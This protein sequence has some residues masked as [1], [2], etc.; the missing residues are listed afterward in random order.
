[1]ALAKEACSAMLENLSCIMAVADAREGVL[2]QLARIIN[3][4]TAH[5]S[6]H[7]SRDNWASR[8]ANG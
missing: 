6:Q 1:M 5:L 4:T 8:A 7:E 2:K 3:I